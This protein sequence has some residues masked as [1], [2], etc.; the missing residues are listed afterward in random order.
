V[1]VTRSLRSRREFNRVYA[2]G[3]KRVGRLLIL[4]LLPAEDDAQ[5]VVASRKIG[6]AVRRNRAKRL[7]REAARAMIWSAEEARQGWRPPRAADA[8]QGTWVVAVARREIVDARIEQVSGE[9][10]RLLR[11]SA[12]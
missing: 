9:L 2:E 12:R 8:P 3:E 4:Y 6:K 5:G 10:E 1:A 11:L 7:L